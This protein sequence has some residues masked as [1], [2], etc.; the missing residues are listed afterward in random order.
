MIINAAKRIND[1]PSRSLNITAQIVFVGD[2]LRISSFIDEIIF[3]PKAFERYF[4]KKK[5]IIDH[6]VINSI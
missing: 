4:F 2:A 6:E 5:N 3:F 1:R